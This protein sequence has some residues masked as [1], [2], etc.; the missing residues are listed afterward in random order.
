[1]ALWLNCDILVN[2]F[3]PQSF[4]YVLFQI[5]TLGKVAQSAEAVEFTDCTSAEG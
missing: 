2:Q 5:N 3:E 1:M 4:Y